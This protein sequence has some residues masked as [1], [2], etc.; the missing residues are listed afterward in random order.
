VISIT[1]RVS[2]PDYLDASGVGISSRRFDVPQRRL[3]IVAC[4]VELAV[5]GFELCRQA[6]DVALGLADLPLPFLDTLVGFVSRGIETA[7]QLFNSNLGVMAR[8]GRSVRIGR[9]ASAG[10]LSGANQLILKR[11]K[12]RLETAPHRIEEPGHRLTNLIVERSH[13]GV[14]P[15]YGVP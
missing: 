13:G 4:L 6:L 1:E 3:D 2:Q 5:R 12:V 15:L 10:L 8:R 11:A 9:D 7:L 14:T